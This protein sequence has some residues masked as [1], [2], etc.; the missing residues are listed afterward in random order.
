[1]KHAAEGRADDAPLLL[2]A[3]GWPWH[4]T[5]PSG[6]YRRPFIE[7]VKAVGLAPG[8]TAYVFRHSSIAR[9][10]LR[11][12]HTKIVADLH[13][14]SEQMIRQ[15]YGKYIIEHTDEIARAALLHDEPPARAKGDPDWRELIMAKAKKEINKAGQST[16]L[17]LDDMRWRPLAKIIERLFPIIGNKGLIA[18]DLTEA[19]ASGK[20]RCKRRHTNE[21]MLNADPLSDAQLYAMAV[22]KVADEVGHHGPAGRELLPASFWVE[23][24]LACSPNGDIRVGL[25]P[26]SRPSFTWTANWVFYL[27]EPDCVEVWHALAPHVREADASEPSPSG[28]LPDLTAD[29]VTD[30]IDII[31]TELKRRKSAGESRL[32]N[33]KAQ[34]LLRKGLSVTLDQA[35]D[36]RLLDACIRPARHQ[37][38]KEI[39]RNSRN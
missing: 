22:G 14:T 36:R 25:R 39:S 29:Q 32:S 35:S 27:W 13:D 3:D 7:I 12:L 31:L 20:I 16:Q 10:L 33:H 30:G 15:H 38:R 19:L 5:N 9:M 28:R 6:D 37:H 1:L 4:E 24:C 17:P 18:Q 34:S 2:Q 23:C 21:Y 11:K 26:P 8:V